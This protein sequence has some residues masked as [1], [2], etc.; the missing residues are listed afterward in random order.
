MPP[1][2]FEL[3]MFKSLER[4]FVIKFIF[5]LHTLFHAYLTNT[6]FSTKGVYCNTDKDYLIYV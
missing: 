3:I 6:F 2:A 4:K 1:L 5:H